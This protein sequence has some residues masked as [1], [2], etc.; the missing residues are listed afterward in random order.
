MNAPLRWLPD[1][2]EDTDAFAC[3]ADVLRDRFA[4]AFALGDNL[5][6]ERV[7][8]MQFIRNCFAHA[9]AARIE[10]FMP[11]LLSLR[12]R[13]GALIAAFGLRSAGGA[14]LFLE[15]YLDTPIEQQISARFGQSVPREAI[16]EVGNLS[17]VHA[18]ATRWL[19]VAVT[20]LLQREG[21]RWIT[22][23]AT[24]VVRN[25]LH[26]L[27]LRPH[28]LAPAELQRL[29]ERERAQWGN[30]Y[31]QSP[32]VMVGEVARG[33]GALQADVRLLQVLE[34]KRAQPAARNDA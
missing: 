20:L 19:M 33:Y 15:H 13:Q 29:P 24:S 3:Q 26:R 30:Y 1:L 11:R 16:V 6:S 25:G 32:T 9:H 5:E 12:D 18:G 7:E 34:G 22:F 10:H 2:A 4:Q 27:G 23:T 31:Q 8:V 14:P 21:F 28:V 17:A